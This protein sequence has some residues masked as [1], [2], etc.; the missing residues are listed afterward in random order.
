MHAIKI[1]FL[2]SH[3]IYSLIS[4]IIISIII[5]IAIF[6]YIY[7]MLLKN[8]PAESLIADFVIHYHPCYH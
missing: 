1:M 3:Q 6:P 7:L 5:T 4:L 2:F 8:S